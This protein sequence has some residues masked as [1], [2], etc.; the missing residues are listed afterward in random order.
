MCKVFSRPY[1]T[2]VRGVLRAFSYDC[3][4][5]N[6]SIRISPP[7]DG[8]EA[9]VIVAITEDS[10]WQ[11]SDWQ[12]LSVQDAKGS[13]VKVNRML[14]E[15]EVEKDEGPRWWIEQG[16][17]CGSQRLFLR[18]GMS[19]TGEAEIAIGQPGRLQT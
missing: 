13:F 9:E 2:S 19:W 17:V 10:R 5:R 4:A 16:R 12:I 8:E 15:I 11:Y 3:D 6:I 7:T 18:L 14:E 1:P